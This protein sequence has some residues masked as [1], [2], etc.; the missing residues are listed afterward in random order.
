LVQPPQAKPADIVVLTVDH[1][2][3][4]VAGAAD[5]HCARRDVDRPAEG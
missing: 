3:E 4:A 5:R 1:D 2:R